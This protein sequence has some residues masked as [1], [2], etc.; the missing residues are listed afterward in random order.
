MMNIPAYLQPGDLIGITCPASKMDR[1]VAEFAAGVLSSWGYRVRI[2]NT[3]GMHYH[4]FSAPDEV[5]RGELQEMLDD[6]EIRAILFGRGGYGMVR[7]IDQLDFSRF[8]QYPKWLCG[9]SDI[10]TLHLH[11]HARLGIPTLHS[12]MCSGITSL[13]VQD[14]YVESLRQVWRG[15]DIHYHFP[16]HPLNRQGTCRGMLIGGNLS[17]LTNLS[18]TAAAPDMARKILL[19]EDVGEYLYNIDRMMMNLK[20][21]GWLEKLSGLLLGS[22]TASQETDTPFGQTAYEIILDKV[23]EYAFPVAFG[24]PAGH[25]PE[26]YTLKLGVPYTLHTGEPCFLKE[27]TQPAPYHDHHPALS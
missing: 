26:N 3:A 5:R 15:G 2:G 17:L 8:C 12:M 1:P 11:V 20:R 22:F 18:G 7:I 21:A 13:T 24:F 9:Y 19:I 14:P 25:Q 4:N 10:T 6:P 27:E 23:K 16:A